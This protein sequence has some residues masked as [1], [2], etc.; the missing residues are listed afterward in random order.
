MRGLVGA[1]GSPA[2]EQMS[3]RSPLSYSWAF[4]YPIRIPL[5]LRLVSMLFPLLTWMCDCMS[6]PSCWPLSYLSLGW[7]W[8]TFISL[9]SPLHSFICTVSCS[10]RG[11]ILF[12]VAQTHGFELSLCQELAE[13]P[14]KSPCCLRGSQLSRLSHLGNGLPGRIPLWDINSRRAET[15][16]SLVG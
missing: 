14:P 10:L 4:L 9:F 1:V 15:V 16:I 3:V 6:L 11:T 8:N 5:P 7:L 12:A 13:R 2:R